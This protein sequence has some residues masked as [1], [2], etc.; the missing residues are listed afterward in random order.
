[1]EPAE[2]FKLNY[3]TSIVGIPLRGVQLMNLVGQH[4][5]AALA[6]ALDAQI[7]G[8]RTHNKQTVDNVLLVEEILAKNGLPKPARPQTFDD[9]L[10]WSKQASQSAG[11]AV[12]ADS[13]AAAALSAGAFFGD[14]LAALQLEQILLGL[15]PDEPDNKELAVQI[16]GHLGY[17]TRAVEQIALVLRHPALPAKA[18]PP[19]EAAVAAF[20]DAAI[21]AMPAA[22]RHD[23]VVKL[24]NEISRQSPAL[25][26]AF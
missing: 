11:G 8:F 19:L 9:W 5:S 24:R 7:N 2:A 21:D 4:A 10:T 12:S 6:T 18:K 3:L 20:R 13:A 22:Q 23:A 25:A 17:A 15:L 14:L 1:V 16:A 26:T